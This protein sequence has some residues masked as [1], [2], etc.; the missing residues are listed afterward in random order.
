VLFSAVRNYVLEF[1]TEPNELR[2]RWTFTHT[3]ANMFS[4]SSQILSLIQLVNH[5]QI[6]NYNQKLGFCWG[7][8][9]RFQTE[10]FSNRDQNLQQLGVCSGP[11]SA[12]HHQSIPKPNPL[13]GIKGFHQHTRSRKMRNQ[14]YKTSEIPARL[15]TEIWSR[16]ALWAGPTTLPLIKLENQEHSRSTKSLRN[17]RLNWCL[18]K[19]KTRSSR[20]SAQ[21]KWHPRDAE[22]TD[23]PLYL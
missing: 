13:K 8:L 9:K 16:R 12:T 21:N 14:D 22:L 20:M 7:F 10:F 23:P 1:K 5:S 18:P 6:W 2:L 17:P 15:Q 11:K 19:E 3:W 4:R